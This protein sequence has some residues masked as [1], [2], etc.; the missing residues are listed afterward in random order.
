VYFPESRIKA[1]RVDMKSP[2]GTIG[3]IEGAGDDVPDCLR[4][5][6]YDVVFLDDTAL[7][8]ADLSGF[9]V[10]ITGVRAYNIRERLKHT[11]PRL[12]EYVKNGGTLIVQYNVPSGLLLQEIGPYPFSIGQERVCVETAPVTFLDPQHTL[13][14]VPNRITPKDFDGW[15]QERGLYFATRWDKAYDTVLSCHDP[16]EPDRNG[17]LL[18]ARYGKGVF[19]YTGY[20]WFRQLPAGVPGAYRLFVNLISAGT[21]D[22][23]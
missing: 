8:N 10:I 6:G 12:L 14:N 2:G 15:V 19:I 17:G 16:G 4:S 23:K 3:Y 5:I 11:Q 13:L 9:D 7:E 21:H 1:V 22:G 20:S 18:F